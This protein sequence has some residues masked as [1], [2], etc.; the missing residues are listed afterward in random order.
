MKPLV[1]FGKPGSG[2]DTVASSLCEDFKYEKAVM[3]TTRPKRWHE[4]D[5]ISYHFTDDDIFEAMI[6]NNMFIYWGKF[7]GWYYGLSKESVEKLAHPI[8]VANPDMFEPIKETW[9]DAIPIYVECGDVESVIRQVK[10]GDNIEE[11]E[12]R[13][14][15]DLGKYAWV[16]SECDFVVDNSGNVQD[17]VDDILF[18]IAYNNSPDYL[19]DYLY[20]TNNE[21]D[22][23]G[24]KVW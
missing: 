19:E 13:Y 17:C 22:G 3:Y 11:I 2:K 8:I 7:R 5:G 6:D 24:G 23:F 16:K 18:N 20:S 12:R 10:R 9:P 14:N 21:F 1:L 15:K 4:T